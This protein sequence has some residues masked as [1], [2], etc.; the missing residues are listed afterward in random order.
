MNQST[1]AFA[2][3]PA[4]PTTSMNSENSEIARLE[5]RVAE[6]EQR[7]AA[8]Q[9]R[10]DELQKHAYTVSH[11]LKSPLVTILGFVS[12]L[13]RDVAAGNQERIDHDIDRILK[14]ADRMQ[15]Q[16]D[17]LVEPLNG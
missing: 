4:D 3:G 10:N 17:E 14:A 2:A 5:A 13:R 1:V 12:F 7:I 15:E 8:L 9:A 6:Q 11:D 16:L